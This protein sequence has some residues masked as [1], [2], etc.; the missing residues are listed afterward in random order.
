MYP[1]KASYGRHSYLA[2]Q[3]TRAKDLSG[4]KTDWKQANQSVWDIQTFHELLEAVAFLGAMNKR[5]TL[6]YRGQA[7][8]RDPIPALFRDEWPVPFTMG[9]IPINTKSRRCYWETLPLIAKKVFEICEPLGLP[10]PEGLKTIREVQWS[11]IQHYGL[12]PT[13]LVDLTT[14]LRTAAS[15]AMNYQ[16]VTKGE[17]QRTGFLYVVGMPHSTGSV[18]FFVDDNIVLARL[19]SACPPIAKRPHYQDGFLAGRFPFNEPDQKTSGKSSLLRRVVAKFKLIDDGQFWDEDFPVISKTALQP[20]DDA[21]WDKF[22][23][24]FGPKTKFDLEQ[25]AYKF[26]T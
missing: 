10:R 1:L 8:T 17:Q 13:P 4:F 2:W 16:S 18:S 7:S 23:K 3:N 6:F 25:M 11:V 12:W 24:E 21:L 19:Q 9:K 15:F 20:Q 5:L 26:P 14:S 22:R